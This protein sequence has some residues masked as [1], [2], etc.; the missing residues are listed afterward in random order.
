MKKLFILFASALSLMSFK[1]APKVLTLVGASVCVD[2]ISQNPLYLNSTINTNAVTWDVSFLYNPSWYVVRM[3]D[4]TEIRLK[5]S[6][7]YLEKQPSQSAGTPST[8]AWVNPSDGKFMVSPVSSLTSAIAPTTIALTGS[9]GITV[10]GSSPSFTVSRSKRQETYAG[11]TN[12]S[13]VLTVT[14]TSAYSVPPDVQ[15]QVL[16]QTNPNQFIR[17]TAVSTTGCT[18]NVYQ[19]NSVNLLGID[20]LLAA[21]VNVNAA[22]VSILVTEK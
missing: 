10:S 8:I 17:V 21:T 13:G 2:A 15:A 7:V 14:F 20:V 16:P 1:T 6:S 4:S 11:S 19:R 9:N 12:A 5:F 3:K 18:M 22:P